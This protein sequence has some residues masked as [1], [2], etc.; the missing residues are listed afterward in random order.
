VH[1]FVAPLQAQLP[2][3]RDRFGLLDLMRAADLAVT[4]AGMT[5]YELSATGTPAITVCMADNQRPNAEAFDRAGAAP[6]AGRAGDAGLCAAIEKALH[7]LIDA[8][9]IRAAM[10]NRA[11]GLVDGRGASRVAQRLLRLVAA[12]REEPC[13]TRS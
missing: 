8:P 9:A 2:I 12:R 4:G 1:E 13:R 11:R 10:A 3:H 6:C 7:E 5:L